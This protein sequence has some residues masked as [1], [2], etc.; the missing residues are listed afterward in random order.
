MFLIKCVCSLNIKLFVMEYLI[1]K[2]NNIRVDFAPL[3]ESSSTKTNALYFAKLHEAV[4]LQ[5]RNKIRA[6]IIY[7]YMTLKYTTCLNFNS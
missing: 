3:R 2:N 4:D 1:I 6:S 7:N 5:Q